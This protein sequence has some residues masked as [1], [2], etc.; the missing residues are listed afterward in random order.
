MPLKLINKKI[1]TNWEVISKF[2]FDKKFQIS[3]AEKKRGIYFEFSLRL[4][5]K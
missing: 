2:K 3:F 1:K 5:K 4:V